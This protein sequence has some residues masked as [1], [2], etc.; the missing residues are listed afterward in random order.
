M[1]SETEGNGIPGTFTHTSN[2]M[3]NNRPV[4]FNAQRSLFLFFHR[5]SDFQ[6]WIVGP[7][8]GTTNGIMY[9]YDVGA[10]PTTSATTSGGATWT[11]LVGGSFVVDRNV[12]LVCTDQA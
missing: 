1:T 10:D 12:Q 4:Y 5:D 11:V 9:A 6:A 2:N 8:L 7:M 3:F